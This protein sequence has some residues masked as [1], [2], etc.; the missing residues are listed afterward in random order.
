MND[1]D[2]GNITVNADTLELTGGGQ[3][4]TTAFSSGR[5]GDITVNATDSVVISGG[6]PTF[7]DR[8]AST[9]R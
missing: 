3:L 1:G 8:F 5:A 7:A 6:N 2:G 9:L 4:L